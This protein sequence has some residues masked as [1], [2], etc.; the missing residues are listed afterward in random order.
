MIGKRAR[1][2]LV[3]NLPH[4]GTENAIPCHEHP[5]LRAREVSR[6]LA[7]SVRGVWRLASAGQIPPPVRVGGATRWRAS[8]IHEFIGGQKAHASLTKPERR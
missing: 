8:D 2:K 6:L 3:P 5:L 7:I 1:A 4:K